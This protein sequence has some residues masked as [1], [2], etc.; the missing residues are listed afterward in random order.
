[1]KKKDI[2]LTFDYELF[3]RD[4]GS[5][6]KCI[7]E[8]TKKLIEVFK[9][10]KIRATFFI[11]IMYYQRL[12]KEKRTIDTSKKIKEQLQ[13]LVANGHR[14]ELHLHPHWVDAVYNRK[15]WEFPTY[16]NYRLHNFT[17]VEIID[18][19]KEGIQI[20]EGLAQE[21]ENNYK[22][23]AFRAGGL[24]IQPFTKLKKAF[25]ELD[26]KIDSSVTSG[27]FGSGEAHEFDFR[28]APNLDYYKFS[29]DVLKVDSKGDFLELPIHTYE[30]NLYNKF[31]NKI[32][33]SKTD[34]KIFGDGTYIGLSQPSFIKKWQTRAKTS[35]T[36][37]SLENI[38]KNI[39]AKEILKSEKNT[40]T[41][42]SHPKSLSPASFDTIEKL[43]LDGHKFL[44]IED[45]Y[46][47]IKI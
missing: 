23:I 33:L 2:L 14:I 34:N 40:I 46:S 11:D 6:E 13:E 22:I 37:F 1:M 4:S 39:L 27:F 26:I 9:R 19:F 36:F 10:H 24:C 5:A 12:I 25:T 38:Y 31:R 28:N 44:N 18:F 47:K 7:L 16:K 43:V 41:V 30:M 8:P 15:S 32:L 3:F 42:L 20:L 17:E 45:W 35:N 21:V 29:N